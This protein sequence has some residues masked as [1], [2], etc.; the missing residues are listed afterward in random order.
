MTIP[1]KPTLEET[2]KR[3]S[4]VAPE[5]VRQMQDVVKRLQDR[6]VLQQ[7][8]YGLKPPL[9]GDKP[10]IPTSQGTRMMN[11]IQQGG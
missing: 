3:N 8:R 7:S 1:T 10:A 6:G 9:G 2:S 4:A 11:R 5:R